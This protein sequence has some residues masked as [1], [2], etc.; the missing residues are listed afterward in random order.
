MCPVILL[1][2]IQ[3]YSLTAWVGSAALGLSYFAAPLAGRLSERFGCRVITIFGGLTCAVSLFITS[4]AKT[5]IHM[6]FS[7]S[8]MFGLGAACV[9]TCT[10]LIAAKY[11]HRRRSF[12]TGVV[13]SGPGI[14][15]FVYGPLIQQLLVWIGLQNTY[16]ALTGFSLLVCL[17]AGTFSPNV[18][19]EKEEHKCRMETSQGENDSSENKTSFSWRNVLNCSAW[20][21][22]TFTI[23]TITFTVIA[24]GDYV[25]LTHL[26][27]CV[28]ACW[29]T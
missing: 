22:P 8:L 27:S 3:L 15:M 24:L 29:V 11:F 28:H 2:L 20:K 18:D 6:F 7:Y 21:T 19:E 26:V 1:K 17:L 13:S 16:R 23:I 12:A 4:L 10:F 25:P 14:G 5:M 9:R